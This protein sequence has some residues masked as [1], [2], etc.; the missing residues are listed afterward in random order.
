MANESIVYNITHPVK[1]T[2]RSQTEQTFS[3]T[4]Q[5]TYTQSQVI[6]SYPRGE[7][8]VH[9][10]K[11]GVVELLGGILPAVL[12]YEYLSIIYLLACIVSAIAFYGIVYYR[13]NR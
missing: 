6:F 4:T 8:I 3:E 10:P 2:V 7:T 1:V 12:Q 11:I 13:K 9:D 5:E